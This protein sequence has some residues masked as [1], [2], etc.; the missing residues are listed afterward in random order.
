MTLRKRIA[1]TVAS[2]L[3]DIGCLYLCFL[4]AGWSGVLIGFCMPVLMAARLSAF[5]LREVYEAGKK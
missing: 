4:I 3:F 5:K 1:L 2:T